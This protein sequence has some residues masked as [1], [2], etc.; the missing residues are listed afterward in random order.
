MKASREMGRDG[1]ISPIEY[2]IHKGVSIFHHII[3]HREPSLGIGISD[4]DVVR[5]LEFL[6]KGSLPELRISS[7]WQS[8]RKGRETSKEERHDSGV[9]P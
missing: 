9:L 3:T 7:W 4:D 6:S 2:I 1:E 5:R 8:T